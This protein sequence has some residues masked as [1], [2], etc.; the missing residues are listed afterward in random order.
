MHILTQFVVN[1]CN[2][3]NI[4]HFTND[5]KVIILHH[6]NS[7]ACLSENTTIKKQEMKYCRL[8]LQKHRRKYVLEWT[9]V[10][11]SRTKKNYNQKMLK[12]EHIKKKNPVEKNCIFEVQI[13]KFLKFIR[14]P[15]C[16]TW[17]HLVGKHGKTLVT[18]VNPSPQ[19]STACCSY[20]I[21]CQSCHHHTLWC[22]FSLFGYFFWQHS[23]WQIKRQLCVMWITFTAA[24]R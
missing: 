19:W 8:K 10:S 6:K 18:R 3:F 16:H 24:D 21:I 9:V 14:L 1:G 2:S 11:H 15:E 4:T 5:M 20:G 13:Y 17:Y 23:D 22:C 12:T 7:K